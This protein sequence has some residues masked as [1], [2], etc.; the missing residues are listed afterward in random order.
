MNWLSWDIAITIANPLTKPSITGSGTILINF[1]SLRI[2]AINCR[3]PIKI[4]VANKYSVP[5]SITRATITTA[6]APVAPEIIPGRPPT[7]AVI[8]PTINAA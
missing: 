6:N 2:P 1:P 4:T 5:W 7:K 8:K 3:I